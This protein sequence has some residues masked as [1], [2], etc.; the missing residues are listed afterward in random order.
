M[1]ALRQNGPVLWVQRPLNRLAT[2]GRPL[3]KGAEALRR[4][5]QERFPLYANAADLIVENTAA[6]DAVV[7]DAERKVR[8]AFGQTNRQT[9]KK[10]RQKVYDH[11]HKKRNAAGGA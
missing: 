11:L 10:E 1:H 5:E 8:E 6:F 2:A 4:M 3:S 9:N 7:Q